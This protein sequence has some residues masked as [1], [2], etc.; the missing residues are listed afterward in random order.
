MA[1][2]N[3][4]HSNHYLDTATVGLPPRTTTK[5]IAETLKLWEEGN[6]DI[7]AFD[8]AIEAAT[9]D[10]ASLV[11]TSHKNIGIISQVSTASAQVAASVSPGGTVLLAMEDFTS[12]L[13]PF[14]TRASMGQ[15]NL[16][17]VP[18]VK[19]IDSIDDS[20]ELAAVSAVQSSS[21]KVIDLTVLSERCK[22]HGVR[23]YLD[24]TQAITWLDI[25]SELF[26]V[27]AVAAYK[28]LCS[29]RGTGFIYV[30]EEARNWLQPIFSNWYAGENP[31]TSIYGPP[32]RLASDTRRYQLSPDW[33]GWVGA[34]HSMDLISKIG[35][36]AIKNHNLELSNAF[37]NEYGLGPTDSAIVS[38]P[39]ELQP[40]LLHER[41]LRTSYR[42]NNLRL[43]FHFYNNLNDVEAMLQLLRDSAKSL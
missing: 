19:F 23:S 24:A 29:P 35:V 42:N 2:S 15:I 25:N 27:I 12:V 31:W 14:M 11:K 38:I 37:T 22:L 20:I 30:Q 33:F 5:A 39:V 36:A 16:R 8:Q 28:W 10:F 4:H 18:L 34:Q 9:R 1:Q 41:N 32:L 43:S 17:I 6:L 40:Q 13:F 7:L 21:G 3:F 26:D